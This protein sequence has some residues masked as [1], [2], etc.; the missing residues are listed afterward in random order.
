VRKAAD[1]IDS[2]AAREKLAALVRV[3]NSA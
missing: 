2:G 1:V 3:S